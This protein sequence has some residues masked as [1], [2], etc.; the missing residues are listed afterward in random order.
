MFE[1]IREIFPEREERIIYKKLFFGISFLLVMLIAVS[2]LSKNKPCKLAV[3]A[4]FKNEAPYLKEWLDHHIDLGVGLF[5]LYNN[6]S[7]DHYLEVLTPYIEQGIVKL[8]DWEFRPEREVR[9]FDDFFIW[10][11][12]RGACRDC[13][14]RAEKKAEWV[15]IIDI[16][17]YIVPNMSSTDFFNLLDKEKK[18]K[19]ASLMVF[20]KNFGTSGVY[21]LAKGEKLVDHLTRCAQEDYKD[22]TLPKSIHRPEMIHTVLIHHAHKLHKRY[23]KRGYQIKKMPKDLCRINHYWSGTE[24]RFW[25]KRTTNKEIG[26][27]IL[28]ELNAV[29]DDSIKKFK[30][31]NSKK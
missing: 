8:I 23:K 30:F 3:G 5:Y 11:L 25:S 27:A 12:H 17:E 24:E 22:H 10:P 29:E 26:E 16:D 20:W 4:L 21:S 1:N 31:F 28:K 14:K 13:L 2:I 19:T 6:E 15:A 18:E 9:G 7:T